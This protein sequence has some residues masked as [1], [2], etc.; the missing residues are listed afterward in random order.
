LDSELMRL[1]DAANDR[2]SFWEES[3]PSL[4]ADGGV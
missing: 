2:L 4:A 3:I 1:S